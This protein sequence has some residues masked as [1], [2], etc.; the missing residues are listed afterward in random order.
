MSSLDIPD[1]MS[2]ATACTTGTWSIFCNIVDN[3]GDIGVSW[4]LARQ[5]ANEHHF[6]VELWVDD[7]PT[8]Q[9]FLRPLEPDITDTNIV[10]DNVRLRH[11][12]APWPDEPEFSRQ[13]A[14]SSVV[15]EMFG[16]EVPAPVLAAM[17]RTSPTPR[18]INI[19][20][21]SAEHWVG[22]LHNLPSPQ[23]L[24]VDGQPQTLQKTFFMPGFA[25]DT[26]G[27]IRE[28][29]LPEQHHQWQR[30]QHSLRQQTLDAFDLDDTFALWI[31]LFCYQSSSLTNWLQ[32]LANGNE[33]VLCIASEGK[34]AA[35]L[36]PL[37]GLKARPQAGQVLRTRALT[38][39][40]HPFVSQQDY[41]RLLS[42]C[43]LNLVRGEDSFVRAQW[44]GKPFIWHIYP[45][46]DNAHLAKL[47][48]FLELFATEDGNSSA[49]QLWREL[50]VQWNLDDDIGNL[51]Q[52]LRPNLPA[53]LQSTRNWQQKL[54]AMPDLT[55]A[56]V[57]SA[58]FAP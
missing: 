16:C 8:L 48:A 45:Q 29:N 46:H 3:Y 27:L 4:R 24:K 9:D 35:M 10:I 20:Y 22:G 40:I 15:L 49:I 21:L 26:G 47:Q 6:R 11:W 25:S 43:D 41:D 42:L 58:G 53:L 50:C 51:W 14:E 17:T 2:T 34:M 44:T 13:V 52:N 36:G 23:Q 1:P 5:L 56:L 39:V 30:Q 18:W 12:P 38:V 7:W 31:S 19:E 28:R 57:R 55:T 32:T 33:P 54:A 37:F